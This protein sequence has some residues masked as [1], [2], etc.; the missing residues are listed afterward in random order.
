MWAKQLLAFLVWKC[1]FQNVFS[2]LATRCDTGTNINT[3]TYPSDSVAVENKFARLGIHNCPVFETLG[4]C[5]VFKHRNG[6]KKPCVNTRYF[7]TMWRIS[8]PWSRRMAKRN[9]D[10]KILEPNCSRSAP[11][12]YA[13][14]S[15]NAEIPGHTS[16]HLLITWKG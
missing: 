1:L 13:Q 4:I 16:E 3:P 10:K 8:P 11:N 5:L 7:L 9:N 12:H 14:R 2:K 6:T 15:T